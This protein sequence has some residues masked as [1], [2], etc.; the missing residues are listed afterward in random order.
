M[1]EARALPSSSTA[2]P[3]TAAAPAATTASGAAAEE[4]AAGTSSNSKAPRPLVE[5]YLTRL[6]GLYNQ[7]A[8]ATMLFQSPQAAALL[9]APLP[10]YSGQPLVA[11]AKDPKVFVKQLQGQ[12]LQA[13]LPLWSNPR[14]GQASPGVLGA[15]IRVLQT[16]AQGVGQ[17]SM[18]LR[19]GAGAS[20]RR[21]AV[22][23]LAQPN[24][25]TVQ[26][27]VE[28]GFSQARAEEA[29]RRVG[30]NSVELAMEWLITH[31]EEPAAPAAAAAAGGEAAGE[32]AAGAAAAGGE[33]GE[34]AADA[35]GGAAAAEEEVDEEEQLSRAL[36]ASLSAIGLN[37]DQ[38]QSTS[39]AA[40][41]AAP[42]TAAAR[43]GEGTS[44][45][46]AAAPAAAAD[47]SGPSV[48]MTDAPAATADQPAA[49]TP[50]PATPPTAA[51]A[52]ASAAADG[53]IP[54]PV[55][56]VQGAVSLACSSPSIVLSVTDLLVTLSGRND[57]K[58]RELIVG[59]LLD[60]FC[61]PATSKGSSAA[62]EP[63]SS[64]RSEGAAGG[65]AGGQS[66]DRLT[67]ARLLLLVLHKDAAA[68]EVA[69]AKGVVPRLLQLLASWQ[70]QYSAAV[71]AVGLPAGGKLPQGLSGEE[72]EKL[73]TTLEVPVWVEAA[74][75]VLDLLATTVPKP[76]QAERGSGAR[77]GAA[78]AGNGAG[79]AG[80]R[81]AA[82]LGAAAGAAEAAAPA[83]DAAAAGGGDVVMEAAAGDAG[84]G[85]AG[86]VEGAAAQSSEAAAAAAGDTGGGQSGGT[87]SEAI[88]A[89]GVAST[90]TQSA[91]APAAA[92]GEG[93]S[94][95][96]PA[97]ATGAATA[98]VTLPPEFASLPGLAEVISNWRPCGLLDD[99]QQEQAVGFCMGLLQ[100]IADHADKWYRPDVSMFEAEGSLPNPSGLTQALLQFL[101]RLT[102]RHSLA[103]Q[104]G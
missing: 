20:P 99:T 38:V 18:L 59:E 95:A 37:P 87:G 33:A 71:A 69:A 76:P 90:S 13:V 8:S 100:L 31:P 68:R 4:A 102:R 78:R 63:T 6:L 11:P 50:P 44:A 93:G 83:E 48:E 22:R 67:P 49:A 28:M 77:A 1:R 86:A 19:Y 24:A 74:L 84:A 40:S 7:L 10:N 42:S 39:L 17:A 75:L 53:A 57:G 35:A 9:V 56:L 70:Q 104:V 85:A 101:V 91:A 45:A 3:T 73:R 82:G 64:S 30:A 29:L 34:A 5:A 89:A 80:A 94:Q 2:P 46:A 51:A 58:D 103:M 26:Q 62:N 61:G 60:K 32:A 92:A 79:A 14:A 15:L 21:T 47:N 23:T 52:A 81:A 25:A 16:C 65:G 72:A 27:I 55:K 43:E 98:S 12:I 66:E 97:G 54:G 88:P 41:P 36:I 96:P